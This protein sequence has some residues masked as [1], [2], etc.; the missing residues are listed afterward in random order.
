L[1]KKHYPVNLPDTKLKLIKQKKNKKSERGEREYKN[2][3]L[4]C[5]FSPTSNGDL[6]PVIDP[7]Q[8]GENES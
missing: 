4:S 8:R 1:L 5:V 6:N 2:D 3:L 7:V